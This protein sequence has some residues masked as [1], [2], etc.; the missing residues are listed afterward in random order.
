MKAWSSR[1]GSPPAQRRE[2]D[3]LLAAE[4]VVHETRGE[5]RRLGDAKADEVAIS[6][7]QIPAAGSLDNVK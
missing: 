5:P 1:S 6:V 4:V 2:Q 3:L 7:R